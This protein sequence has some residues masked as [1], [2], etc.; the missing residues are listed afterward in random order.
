M[1]YHLVQYLKKGKNLLVIERNRNIE[2]WNANVKQGQQK[3]MMLKV[4]LFIK[5]QTLLVTFVG[6][7]LKATLCYQQKTTNRNSHK[8]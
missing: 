7:R 6:Q 5:V 2:N 8:N 1:K 3:L 4:H